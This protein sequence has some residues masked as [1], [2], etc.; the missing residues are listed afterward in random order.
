[1][2]KLKQIKIYDNNGKTLDRYT[3]VYMFSPENQANTYSAR[4]MSE[5]PFHPQGFG[6][7]CT[8]M[9]GRHLGKRIKFLDLPSDCQK[10]ILQDIE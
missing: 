10:L 3:A 2:N 1:M 7:Y 9:P 5:R 8:A 4:A 6:Q